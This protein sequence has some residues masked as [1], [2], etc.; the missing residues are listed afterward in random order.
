VPVPPVERAAPDH[1][2]DTL[3]ADLSRLAA[4]SV[5]DVYAAFLPGRPLPAIL[6]DVRRR[7]A[8]RVA[9]ALLEWLLDGPLRGKLEEID[10]D[11]LVEMLPRGLVALGLM[12]D[13]GS[14]GADGGDGR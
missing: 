2:L 9:L 13:T 7:K 11:V 10:C 12:P 6:R 4:D 14:V 5:E 1:N 8:G 3:K